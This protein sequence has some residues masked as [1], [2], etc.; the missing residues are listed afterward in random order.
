[1]KTQ[2]GSDGS[3]K[4]GATSQILWSMFDS[5]GHP[6]ERSRTKTIIRFLK[7]TKRESGRKH[8][9][10]RTGQ[11]G[12][13]QSTTC[14]RLVVRSNFQNYFVVQYYTAHIHCRT[15]RL[16]RK[17]DYLYRS[18][19]ITHPA[20]FGDLSFVVLNDAPSSRMIVLPL[21]NFRFLY[22]ITTFEVRASMPCSN[23]KQFER[24]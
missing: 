5:N 22:R 10:R 18:Q 12:R 9:K 3:T 14:R 21:I 24:K 4:A 11:E 15:Q 16:D 20:D 2:N 6:T 1:M 23:G 13:R 7:K 17:K 8:F 19:R